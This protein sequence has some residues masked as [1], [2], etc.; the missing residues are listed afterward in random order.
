VKRTDTKGFTLIE[1][2][3]VIAIIAILAGMLL[4][5]L[6]KA[7]SKAQGAKCMSNLRQFGI[8]TLVYINDQGVYPVGID[9]TG[10]DPVWIWPTLLR[11]SMYSG[12]STEVFRCPAAPQTAQWIP[13]FG[14]GLAPKLG[15]LQDEVRLKPGAVSYMSY[16]YNV[17]GAFA[18]NNPNT[19]LGVYLGD[20]VWGETKESAVVKPSEMIAFG[21][22]NWDLKKKGDRDWSGFIGMYEER[23]WPLELH[24]GRAEILYCDGHVQARKRLDMIGQL[25]KDVS[26]GQSVAMQWNRDNKPHFP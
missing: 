11:A 2:L 24:N 25:H 6:S 3:V 8:A 26:R 21:D 10:P 18:G 14:S 16:G 15:Y 23:Q 7:K 22:S 12:Q 17:W 4:P 9:A 19:G 1:L 13:K 20:K 5:A